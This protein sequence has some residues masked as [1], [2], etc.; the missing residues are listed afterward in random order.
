MDET[1]LPKVDASYKRPWKLL[2][3]FIDAREEP[4]IIDGK[5][6][7]STRVFIDEYFRL[8]V[9]GLAIGIDAA[10]R[11]AARRSQDPGTPWHFT[12]TSD[13]RL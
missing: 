13:T 12:L 9:H 8:V 2:K 7:Y 5:P 1:T 11:E 3:E 4:T 10:I 6:H